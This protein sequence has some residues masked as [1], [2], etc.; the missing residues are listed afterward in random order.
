MEPQNRVNM[1][2]NFLKRSA[3]FG[4][5]NTCFPAGFENDLLLYVCNVFDQR[6]AALC[7]QAPIHSTDFPAKYTV[8][9]NSEG[10][11]LPIHRASAAHRK[12][13]M[14]KEVKPIDHFVW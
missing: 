5:R 9:G 7:L 4:I 12:I 11:S 10:C 8:D 13:G 6:E 3:W 1:V 2:D 14:P